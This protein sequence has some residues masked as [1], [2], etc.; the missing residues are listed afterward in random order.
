MTVP[1]IPNSNRL[2]DYTAGVG[3][4][5]FTVPWIVI[6]DSE[7]LAS[8]DIGMLINNVVIDPATLSFVGNVISGLSGIWNGGTVTRSSPCVG[9]ERV[10]LYSNR[11][12]R[13]TGNFLEGKALPFSEL[14]KLQ[15]DIVVQLRDMDLRL[16]RAPLVSVKDYIDG[17]DPNTVTTTVAAAA[18]SAVSAA[19][20][21]NGA[22]GTVGSGASLWQ[23]PVKSIQTSPP[24]GP[25]TGDRYLVAHSGTS[26]AFVGKEDNVA[27]WNSAIWIYSGAPQ[28]NQTIDIGTTTYRYSQE[29]F[30]VG[31][32]WRPAFFGGGGARNLGAPVDSP[33]A[34][35]AVSVDGRPVCMTATAIG[36]VGCPLHFGKARGTPA[37]MTMPLN[38]DN[39]ISI[40]G[41]AYDT[42]ATTFAVSSSAILS[43]LTEDA[44][45][46][47][48][49]SGSNLLFETTANGGGK[50]RRTVMRIDADG[51]TAFFGTSGSGAAATFAPGAGSVRW[52]YGPEDDAG[53]GIQSRNTVGIFLNR[54]GSDGDTIV[55]ER[56]TVTVGSISVSGAAT[57]YNTACDERLKRIVAAP[58]RRSVFDLARPRHFQWRSSGA[59]DF[60]FLAQELYLA[61]PGAV[62][63]GSPAGVRPDDP[64]FTPWQVDNS[65]LVPDLWEETRRLRQRVRVLEISVCIIGVALLAL[66]LKV[67]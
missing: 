59:L 52:F 32:A 1:S 64:G 20:S 51:K 21:A 41:R 42:T 58:K 44:R 63:V 27:E 53:M 38:G 49:Y 2:A 34:V 14:D 17:V 45:A 29:A 61:R 39:L 5:A 15:D 4:T 40:G 12:P 56:E 31:I 46:G 67:L 66:A 54:N 22:A 19:A 62:K 23:R 3:Q 48:A 47:T 7:V 37:A 24:G 9:G 16:K 18:A 26:G 50:L 13:R 65:K 57:A 43:Y 8:A 11:A 55:F 33:A 25:A 60:G 6:A 30:D 10:I 35:E 36:A 28:I